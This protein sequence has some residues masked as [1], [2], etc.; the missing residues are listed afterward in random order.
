MKSGKHRD[1]IARKEK[2]I[3]F[4]MEG[5]GV[6]GNVPC[7]IIKGV[8]DYADSHKN[9]LWQAYAAATGASA[10]KAFLEYWMPATHKDTSRYH[11]LMV[12]VSHDDNPV[13]PPYLQAL[14]CP[15]PFIV[16]N[17]LKASKDKLLSKAIEW[18]FQN[19]QYCLWQKEDDVRLLWI[20]G[21]AG[22]GKTMMTIG[23]VEQLSRDDTSIV[24]YFFCQNTD[25]ELNSVEGI[26]K[27][28]IQELIRQRKE[29]LELLQRRW[30]AT[31]AC[32][33]ENMSSWRI[34]WDIFLEMIDHCR[35]QRLY[36]VGDALDECQN[37]GM[38][39]FLR[40]IV[41]TGLDHSYVR[42]L[43]TSRPLDDADHELLTTAEQV[44]I[45]LEL[46]SNHLEAAIKTYVKHKVRYLYPLDDYGQ[47]MPQQ[48][49]SELLQR[50]EGT[51]LWISL[52][53]RTLEDDGSDGRVPPN[54]AL[55]MI[56]D[57]PPGLNPL[58]EQILQQILKGKLAAVNACLRLL[59]V[60]M[61]VFRPLNRAEVLSVTGIPEEEVASEKIINRCSSF[62]KAR[63]TAIEFVHQSS[64]DFLAE[65]PLFNSYD[66]YG[67]GDIALRCLAY[68]STVLVPN[69]VGLPLP[70][71]RPLPTSPEG[72]DF[73]DKV[74]VLNTLDYAATFWAEHLHAASKTILVQ[75]ALGDHGKVLKFINEKLLEWLECLSLLGRLSYAVKIL[76]VLEA[77]AEN[78][79]LHASVQDATRFLLRHYQTISAWPRQIYSSVLVFS[80]EKSIVRAEH[81]LRKAPSWLKRIPQLE[82]TWDSLVQILAGH[83]D[84]VKAVA[85]SPDGKQIA[86]ASG[87]H[88]VRLWDASMG[89]QTTLA[90]HSNWVIEVAFSPDG[91]QIASASSDHTVKLWDAS[92]GNHQKTLSGYSG[93]LTPVAFSPD[94]KQIA[95]ASGDHTIRL[96]DTS[97]GNHQETLAGHSKAVT[98]VA[99]SPDGKKIASASNDKTIR[100]WDASTG[101]QQKILASYSNWITPVA[102]SPDGKQIASASNNGTIRLW[103]ASTGDHQKTLAGHSDWVTAVAFSPD[104]KQIASASDD[105]TVRLWDIGASMRSV[106]LYGTCLVSL[107]KFRKWHRE[108]K[109]PDTVKSL[110]YL[111][112]GQY[113]QTNLGLLKIGDSGFN[114]NLSLKDGWIC[115]GAAQ[116]VKYCVLTLIA[117]RCSNY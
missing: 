93:W 35:G 22:K 56:R 26:I 97:M 18:I 99:F 104:G 5:A 103:D 55:L 44:G 40:I 20:R 107:R 91:K 102:F 90:N 85:F 4:E 14:Q 96:W 28:L 75:D 33:K 68:M 114:G 52:V 86:S 2:V 46:N 92:N 78:Y 47:Q 65:S 105:H 62:I 31:H 113:L 89:D 16:K 54:K 101:N 64:R 48:L 73:N 30:D 15:D 81:N 60:M 72:R 98:A 39:E 24:A 79:L 6:L 51:F 21:G 83:S 106:R 84:E 95:L 61:L 25:Y 57:L 17:R 77:L 76:T 34:L 38:A 36:V 23:L 49:E 66:Q 29:L 116:M 7:I 69:L 53:C 8:C 19:P 87:Y 100:L 10:V 109:V 82:S 41:R 50:A 108:I 32:Y 117:E 70:N 45:S 3:G 74:A 13:N 9:K 63:G 27:G 42:W 1:E 115:Y 67:H 37:K 58:Y 94:S 111:A 110:T 12:P 112:D 43:L 88:T 59:K 11:H 71:S 80:P